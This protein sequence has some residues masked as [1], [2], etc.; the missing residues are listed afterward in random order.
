MK[1]KILGILTLVSSL[2]LLIGCSSES[3]DGTYYEFG[4]FSNTGELYLDKE[5]KIVIQGKDISVD[6]ESYKID[7]EKEM[8]DSGRFEVPYSYEDGV[9]TIKGTGSIY[10]GNAED[11]TF[12]KKDSPKYKE[13]LKEAKVL[14]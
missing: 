6:D 12:V 9:L 11:M 8:I 7:T 13:L 14:E 2:F 10:F 5:E 4:K 3:L 1:K